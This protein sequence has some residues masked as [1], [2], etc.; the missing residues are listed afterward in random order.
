MAYRPVLVLLQLRD[1]SLLRML[2]GT[3]TRDRTLAAFP[4]RIRAMAQAQVATLPMMTTMKARR[5]SRSTLP[6]ASQDEV[7]HRA[8]DAE[9]RRVCSRNAILRRMDMS[10]RAHERKT[11]MDLSCASGEEGTGKQCRRLY[12]RPREVC[13]CHLVWYVHNHLG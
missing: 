2:S 1:V 13:R 9:T 11:R 8:P 10:V 5:I 6:R 3:M 12:L 4:L 7:R